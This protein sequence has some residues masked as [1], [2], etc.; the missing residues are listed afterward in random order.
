MRNRGAVPR[1][2]L[3]TGMRGLARTIVVAVVLA[4]WVLAAPLAAASGACAAMSDMCEGPCGT[5]SCVPGVRVPATILPLAASL[6]LPAADHAPSAAV[7]LPDLPPKPP[8]PSV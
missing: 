2:M 8:L 6:G 4:A 7:R 1:V 3:P 5:A